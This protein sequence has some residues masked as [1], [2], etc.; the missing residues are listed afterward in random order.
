[1]FIRCRNALT[2]A[3]AGIPADLIAIDAVP[4][5]EPIE[6]AAPQPLPGDVVYPDNPVAAPVA[7]ATPSPDAVPGDTATPQ[8]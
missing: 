5:W 8:E 1:M 3:E 6:G 2:G 7:D 4:V